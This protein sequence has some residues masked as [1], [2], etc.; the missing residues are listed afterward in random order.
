MQALRR[1]VVAYARRDASTT[2]RLRDVL[3]TTAVALL[4]ACAGSTAAPAADVRPLTD[5]TLTA[6]D[7]ADASADVQLQ[8]TGSIGFT[9]DGGALRLSTAE[10]EQLPTVQLEVFEPFEERRI[11]FSGVRVADLLDFADVLEQATE[12]YLVAHDDYSVI[13][14]LDAL[15]EDD[16]VIAT[17]EGGQPI[18]LVA[19]GPFRLVFPDGSATGTNQDHW[20]WSVRDID[21]R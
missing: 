2:G 15:L 14:G 17:R 16:A 8:V 13:L 4:A 12:L 11:R 20:I 1:R 21:V 10:L 7:V 6:G 19:G 5:G 9:N 3:V 18:D